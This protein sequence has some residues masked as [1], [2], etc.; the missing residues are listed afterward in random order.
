MFKMVYSKLQYFVPHLPHTGI[1]VRSRCAHKMH[2]SSSADLSAM[3]KLEKQLSLHRNVLVGVDSCYQKLIS[4]AYQVT[5]ST[6]SVMRKFWQIISLEWQEVK[7]CSIVAW[8]SAGA[9][10]RDGWMYYESISLFIYKRFDLF[11]S[12]MIYKL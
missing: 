3:L 11:L 9:F 7:L 1:M 6:R 2:F 12:K 10:A 4:K 8:S 5:Q